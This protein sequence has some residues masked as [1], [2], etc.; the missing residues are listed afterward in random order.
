MDYI[1]V[2]TK[3]IEGIDGQ[4]KLRKGN[5]AQRIGD[6]LWKDGKRICVWRS[7]T[8]K[9]LFFL[10]DDGKGLEKSE[11]L[12]EIRE[13]IGELLE[14]SR[15]LHDQLDVEGMDEEEIAKAHEELQDPNRDKLNALAELPCFATLDAPYQATLEQLEEA[16]ALL[17]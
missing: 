2:K 5:H 17:A 3:T 9:D 15:I 13:R 6:Y 4:F 11:K 7:Q 14:A 16:Y 8:A 1:C 12:N 10:N